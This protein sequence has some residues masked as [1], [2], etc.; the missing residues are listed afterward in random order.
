MDHSSS[1]AAAAAAGRPGAEAGATPPE[2]G[3]NAE[4]RPAPPKPKQLS[5]YCRLV[6]QGRAGG[7]RGHI[8]D[9]ILMLM[10]ASSSAGAW[11]TLH[12]KTL[13]AAG[14]A[15]CGGRMELVL[16]ESDSQWRHVCQSCGYVDYFNPK[17]VREQLGE[18]LSDIWSLLTACRLA[19]GRHRLPHLQRSEPHYSSRSV[20]LGLECCARYAV[21]FAVAARPAVQVVGCVVEHAGKILL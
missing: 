2:A 7:S 6:R 15:Q 11:V 4:P 5:N 20:Q 21:Q 1:S 12:D 14:G 13:V 16:H 18:R 9:C 17:L 19:A 10:T 8:A 3:G